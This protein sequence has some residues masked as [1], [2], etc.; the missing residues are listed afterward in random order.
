[1]SSQVRDK[2]KVNSKENEVLWDG[3]PKL[4]NRTRKGTD[5]EPDEQESYRVGKLIGKVR[6]NNFSTS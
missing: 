4:I 1:M 5:G 2:R 6:T 3:V